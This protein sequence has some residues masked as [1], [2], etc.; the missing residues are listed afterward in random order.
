MVSRVLLPGGELALF[1]AR[2]VG[3][4]RSAGRAVPG[5]FLPPDERSRGRDGCR[6]PAAVLPSARWRR[7]GFRRL[8]ER[9]RSGALVDAETKD[10]L[11]WPTALRT[12]LR[13]GQLCGKR[14]E[15]AAESGRCE[16]DARCPHAAG[17]RWTAAREPVPYAPT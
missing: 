16:L 12:R 2:G 6:H 4:D 14:S 13:Y 3:R 7:T 10:T 9:L 5:L 1:S 8:E 17:T 15:A 11:S